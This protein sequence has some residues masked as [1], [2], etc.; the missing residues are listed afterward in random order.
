MSDARIRSA[1]IFSWLDF[2]G[3]LPSDGDDPHGVV[4]LRVPEFCCPGC[5]WGDQSFCMGQTPRY[6]LAM[7]SCRLLDRLPGDGER[8]LSLDSCGPRGG[9]KCTDVLGTSAGLGSA[10]GA[11]RFPGRS[12]LIAAFRLHDSRHDS[13][14]TLHSA[15]ALKRSRSG[16]RVVR[17]TRALR[18]RILSARRES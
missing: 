4:A 15:P 5:L 3:C 1:Q 2:F 12:G 14:A 6:A 8:S 7:G 11:L 10:F 18:S 9:R 16:D 13:T 17:N